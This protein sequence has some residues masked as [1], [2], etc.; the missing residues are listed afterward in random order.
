MTAVLFIKHFVENRLNALLFLWIKETHFIDKSKSVHIIVLGHNLYF[1]GAKCRM[2]YT[3]II[4]CHPVFILSTLC[5][6]CTKEALVHSLCDL[7][8]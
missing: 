2:R 5:M 8:Y 1:F 4:L 3:V 6:M 7:A